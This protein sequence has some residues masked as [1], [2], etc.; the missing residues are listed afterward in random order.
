MRGN[1]IEV[2]SH[3]KDFVP[4]IAKLEHIRIAKEGL[5][6]IKIKNPEI[7]YR[8]IVDGKPTF[9][10]EE[11]RPFGVI[12]YIFLRLP[13]IGKFAIQTARDLSPVQSGRYKKSWRLI[14]DGKTV[15][16]NQIPNDV[17][18]LVLVNVQPYARKIHLR[19]ARLRNVPPGIVEK[20]KQI[21]N[22]KF[23]SQVKTNIEFLELHA[24]YVL[25]K[26]YV[27]TMAR[28]GVNRL[29]T[30]AGKQI[31]YPALIMSPRD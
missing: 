20:V 15:G 2:I 18:R 30:R 11:V 10:E 5:N 8:I 4:E 23:K 19:G 22:N 24:A 7:P 13:Q 12:K 1:I 14:A 28:H 26:D 21:T 31:T 16:E 29:H 27:Q 3:L 6:R 17:K 25:Q 9:R